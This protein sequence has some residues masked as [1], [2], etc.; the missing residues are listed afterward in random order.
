MVVDFHKT[1]YYGE[2]IVIVGT[3]NVDHNKL[4]ELAQKGFNSLPQKSPGIVMNTHKPKFHTANF[5]MRDD[6]M[7]QSNV[8]VFFE[9]PSWHDED[10]YS[11]LLL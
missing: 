2:N 10:F 8:G 3:G 11:F 1:N 5:Y 4:V 7:A 6:Q 9:A